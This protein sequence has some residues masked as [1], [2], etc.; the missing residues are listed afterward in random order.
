[1]ND[2]LPPD[3]GTKLEQQLAHNAH[4]KLLFNRY[5]GRVYEVAPASS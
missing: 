5:G 2:G 4:F 1:V 3:W